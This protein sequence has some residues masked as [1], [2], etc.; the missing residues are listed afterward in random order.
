MDAHPRPNGSSPKGTIDLL[1]DELCLRWVREADVVVQQTGALATTLILLP[2]EKA[3]DEV[4]IRLDGLRGNLVERADAIVAELRPQTAVHDP[5][6]LV[7]MLAARLGADGSA[8]IGPDETHS[9]Q[10]TDGALVYV[11]LGRP[12]LR[13]ALAFR[14]RR[15][16]DGTSTLERAGD[17]PPVEHFAWLDA[18]LHPTA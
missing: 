3:A 14:L 15:G 10:G 18:L 5:A 17:D 4:A 1:F 8:P 2:R 6:G 7:L 16:A 13:R 12:A 11:S 9:G